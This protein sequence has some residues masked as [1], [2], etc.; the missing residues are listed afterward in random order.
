MG[1]RKIINGNVQSTFCSG[2]GNSFGFTRTRSRSCKRGQLVLFFFCL[3]ALMAWLLP[4]RVLAEESSETDKGGGSEAW[5]EIPI[6][7]RGI[8]IVNEDGAEIVLIDKFGGIYLNGD[9]YFNYEKYNGE[10][11]GEEADRSSFNFIVVYVM[12]GILS[13]LYLVMFCK[14]KGRNGDKHE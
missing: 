1:V 9:V 8:K 14:D 6:D 10:A 7:G 5:A 12:L 3:A 11:A 13:V 4:A 2:I